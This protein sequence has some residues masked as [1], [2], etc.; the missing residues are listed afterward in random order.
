MGHPGGMCV[1]FLI[2]EFFESVG[3]IQG[4]GILRLRVRLHSR[5][6]TSLRMT[7]LLW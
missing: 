3:L 7:N 6:N 5:T 4:I 2:L 1:R